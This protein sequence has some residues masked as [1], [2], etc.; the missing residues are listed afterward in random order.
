M[1][2]L[3]PRGLRFGRSCAAA[4]QRRYNSIASSAELTCLNLCNLRNLRMLCNL[5]NLRI[6]LYDSFHE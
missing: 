1:T 6:L 4:T 2:R 5:R 3:Q